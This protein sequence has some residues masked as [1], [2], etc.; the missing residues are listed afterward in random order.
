[1]AISSS[2][3]APAMPRAQSPSVRL[4]NGA[5]DRGKGIALMV[6]AV[7]LFA[8]MDALVKWLGDGYPTSQ[9]IFFRSLFAFVPL[10]FIM[11]RH[12]LAEA[13]RINDWIGHG[14]RCASGIVAMG[15][16]FYGFTSLPLA[17]VIAIT[18]AA[19][20]FIT[21][22]SVPMLGERVGPRRWA[23]VLAG[24][25]GVLIM[26][27]PGAGVMEPAAVV[28][29]CGMLFYAIAMIY[30]RKLSRTETSTSIVFYFTATA[31]LVSAAFL[32]FHWVTP[33]LFDFALLVAVG[34]V[35]GVAQIAITQ[36][37]RYAD[38]AVIMPFEYTAMIWAALLGFFVW[39]EVPG[40]N[41]WVGVAVVMLSGLYILYREA[42]LGLKR[43]T[44]RK[45]TTKR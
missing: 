38:V 44:A 37:F 25:V 13:V 9:I 18:F 31:T 17:D 21:A 26:V 6:L 2:S 33:N 35:G 23:A 28:V 24:F 39:G 22:L 45:L 5:R 41:I 10:A 42:D 36:A 7:G 29:L 16:M 27:Q 3:P 19:P 11:F 32:P 43:G 14:I 1:M 4:S 20:I 40:N 30:V 12:G 8:V 15:C 34:L